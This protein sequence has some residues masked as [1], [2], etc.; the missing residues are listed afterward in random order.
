MEKEGQ[1][2]FQFGK[3]ELEFSPRE[4][5]RVCQAEYG[6]FLEE[7]NSCQNV[8]KYKVAQITKNSRSAFINCCKTKYLDANYPQLK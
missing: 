4:M 7:L 5:I 1:V 6:Q 2:N 3:Q 8:P